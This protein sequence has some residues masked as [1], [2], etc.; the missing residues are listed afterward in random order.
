MLIE[1]LYRNATDRP[2]ETAIVDDRGTTTFGELAAKSAA[3]AGVL[4]QVS[5]KPNVGVVLPSSAAF[6]ACFYGSLLAGKALVPVN[7]LLSPQQIAHVITDSGVDTIISAPPL[8]EKFA[9]IAQQLGVKL[10]DLS[11]LPTPTTAPTLPALPSPDL[12]SLAILLYTSGTSGLPKGVRLTHRNLGTCIEGCI[13]HAKLRGEHRFL[14]LVPLFH[15]LGLT[16]TL[17]APM[18][19]GTLVVYQARFSPVAAMEKLRSH[20]LSIGIAIPSMYKA[21]LALKSA[22]RADFEHVYAL[23]CGGEPLPATLREAFHDRFGVPLFE[24]YGLSETCGPIS[25]NVPGDTRPGSVGAPSPAPPSA[26][27]TT[28][29]PAS[30]PATSAKSCSVDP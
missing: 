21:F 16:G 13:E 24:G 4:K 25:V 14:G 5:V 17:L 22:G 20:K 27:S 10:I 8:A 7:F 29:T 2:A 11:T 23:I 6:A 30:S 3:L 26:S 28:P 15:S 18:A 9:P 19:L 12:D 1:P